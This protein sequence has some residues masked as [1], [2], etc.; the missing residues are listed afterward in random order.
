MVTLRIFK[1]ATRVI[2][3]T[4]GGSETCLFLLMSTQTNSMV[5]ALLSLKLFFGAHVSVSP[6]S[7]VLVLIADAPI[8]I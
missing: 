3:G 7:C 1:D 2:P 5:L 6:S 4:G 8:M